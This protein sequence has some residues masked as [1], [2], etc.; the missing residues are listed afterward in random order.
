ML[1]EAESSSTES[2]QDIL[3]STA[4]TIFFGCPHRAVEQVPLVDTA[5]SMAEASV[6][7]K[8]E[9]SVL[10]ALCGVNNPR[11]G[12]AQE[13]FVRLWHYFNFTVKT[14]QERQSDTNKFIV[15]LTIFPVS[16]GNELTY[17]R[18]IAG[19]SRASLVT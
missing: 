8:T 12:E 7:I 19:L 4:A 18:R 3:S 2:E 13:S 16:V 17:R 11:W 5:V 6:S 14:Y 15:G 10:S 1:R 9:S